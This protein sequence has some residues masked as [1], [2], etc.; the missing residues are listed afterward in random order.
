MKKLISLE[1]VLSAGTV[2]S[3]LALVIAVGVHL[4]PAVTGGIEAVAAALLAL[5]TAAS[6]DKVTPALWTG[7][8]TAVGTL[9]VAFGVPHVNAGDVSAVYAVLA[10][11]LASLLREKVTPRARTVKPAPATPS[12]WRPAART[13]ATAGRSRAI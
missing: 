1:P 3:V 10:I 13:R 11:V 8:V 6:V 12:R 9:L 2:Q 4:S 5:I 7:L